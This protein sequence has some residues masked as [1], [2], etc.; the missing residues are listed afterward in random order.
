MHNSGLQFTN[1]RKAALFFFPKPLSN[2]P[3]MK[4]YNI[5]FEDFF[6]VGLVVGLNTIQLHH[7]N[8]LKLS[9]LEYENSVNL[10]F[11][12]SFKSIKF[13]LFQCTKDMATELAILYSTDHLSES[14]LWSPELQFQKAALW[15]WLINGKYKHLEYLFMLNQKYFP[16]FVKCLPRGNNW[17]Q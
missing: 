16:C 17:T 14:G 4:H 1:I 8:P 6:S 3:S 5:H 9:W 11:V 13:L 2:V 10:L 12:P 15:S 7:L